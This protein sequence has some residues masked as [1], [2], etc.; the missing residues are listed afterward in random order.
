MSKFLRTIRFDASDDR[1]FARAAAAGEWAVSGAF[2]FAEE[3]AEKRRQLAVIEADLA[4]DV[5]KPG[6]RAAA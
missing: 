5:E 2:A 3:L 1:V 6:E 4:N